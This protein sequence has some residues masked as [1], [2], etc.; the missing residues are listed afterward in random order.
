MHFR[1]CEFPIKPGRAA[2]LADAT[3]EGL[4]G[5]DGGIVLLRL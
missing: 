4:E 2:R 3:K 1:G 5:G